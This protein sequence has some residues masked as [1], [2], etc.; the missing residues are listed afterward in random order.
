MTPARGSRRR[1]WMRTAILFEP[2]TFAQI[3]T[4]AVEGDR[5]FNE[6]VRLLVEWGLEAWHATGAEG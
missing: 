6:Q 3:R 2:D 5:S 4:L 1:D